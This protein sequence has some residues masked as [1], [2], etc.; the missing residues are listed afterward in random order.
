MKKILILCLMFVLAL[1]LNVF[2]ADIVSTDGSPNDSGIYPVQ[3][4]SDRVV[5]FAA[6]AGIKLPYEAAITSDTLTAKE[7]GKTISMACTTPCEIELPAAKAGMEFTFVSIGSTAV[8]SV[9]PNGTDTIY[10]GVGAVPL[11]AG[12]K[13]TS[14]GATGDVL[15]ILSTADGYWSVPIEIGSFTDGGA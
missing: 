4:D 11:D 5:T 13:A 2:A 7:S 8:F 14:P 6:D 10:L 3:V 15:K 12:D 9:D 1:S